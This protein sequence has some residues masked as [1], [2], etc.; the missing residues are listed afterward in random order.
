MMFT[1]CQ[2][3]IEDLPFYYI[4]FVILQ[5]NLQFYYFTISFAFFNLLKFKTEYILR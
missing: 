4:Y 2:Y 1:F 5:S 3:F